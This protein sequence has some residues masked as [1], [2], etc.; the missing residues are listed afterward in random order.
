MSWKTAVDTAMEALVVPSFTKVGYSVRSRLFD[1]PPLA[2]YDLRDKT[3]VLS[4]ATSGLGLAAARQLAALGANLVLVARDADKAG[5][6]ADQLNRAH[7][8]TDASVETA[9]LS[10]LDQVRAACEHIRQRHACIDVLIHNAGAL[11]NQRREAADG[12]EASCQIMV[13]APFLMT[14]LLL[15]RIKVASPGRVI[16]MSSGGMYT[17]PLTV[18]ELEMS[19]QDY[20]GP[21]QYARAKRAQVVLNEMWAER[22]A[23]RQAV[24]HALHPGWAR[25][26]GI[27]DALPGF[28]RIIGPLLRTPQQGADTLVWL[29][30]SPQAATGS[31]AFWLDR[32]VRPTHKLNST[33]ASDTPANRQAL[34]DW[35][36]ERAGVDAP[37]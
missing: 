20:S 3:I 27:T 32:A 11:F 16:T 31:G 28:S 4:G 10:D 30:A 5:R 23:A 6:L 25:T 35:C 21:K 34:W 37:A 29:A 22:I 33:R 14:A 24:F 18:N 9:D 19:E 15:D 2:A 17:A 26:P 12:T 7:P 13:V 8:A 1:W 36:V